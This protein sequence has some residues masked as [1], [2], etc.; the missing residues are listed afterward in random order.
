M[1]DEAI[2]AARRIVN[3]ADQITADKS[4]GAVLHWSR[5][6]GDALTLEGTNV[7]RALLAAAERIEVL[8]A[9]LKEMPD[10]AQR[11]A[12]QFLDSQSNFVLRGPAGLAMN[13]VAV[14]RELARK[15]L[16]P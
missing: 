2:E 10:E 14:I 5:Q 7:A 13:I 8:E 9:A 11:A 16:E 3:A 6:H 15:A 4:L 12:N 1:T